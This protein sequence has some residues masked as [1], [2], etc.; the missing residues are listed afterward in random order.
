M[1]S[2]AARTNVS[3]GQI[4]MCVCVPAR[5][6]ARRLP[7]LLDALAAQDWAEPVSVCIAINNSTDDSIAVMEAMRQRH[8]DRLVLHVENAD[9]P[10]EL[11]HAGSARRMAMDAG[12]AVLGSANGAILVSTDADTRPPPEWLS[13]IAAQVVNGAD[14]VG[15]RLDIDPLEPLSPPVLRLRQAWDGYWAAVRAIEDEIDPIAWDP[16]PRHGDHTGASLAIRAAIY[17]A[18][19]GVPLMQTGED[20]VLVNAALAIGARLV[21]PDSVYTYV[22]PRLEGRAAGGMAAAMQDLHDAADNQAVP[23]APSFQHWRAR[24]KWRREMRSLP[25]GH[26]LISRHEPLLPPMPCDMPIGIGV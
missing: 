24:A 7:V 11:A 5:N 12:L 21:H 18:C 22:S 14:L 10:P 16:S 8:A 23:M 3:V 15:G 4:A 17:C 20:R 1:G 2:H 26:A 9:F 13:S 25:G 19:G 6:E